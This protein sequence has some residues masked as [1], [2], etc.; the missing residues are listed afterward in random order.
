MNNYV[1]RAESCLAPKIDASGAE[2]DER[3]LMDLGQNRLINW[4]VCTFS[5]DYTL[6]W[7]ANQC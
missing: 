1:A 3:E 2:E 4:L 6:F 7:I 5:P